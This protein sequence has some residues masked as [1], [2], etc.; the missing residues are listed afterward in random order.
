MVKIGHYIHTNHK[1]RS[2]GLFLE[3]TKY[4]ETSSRLKFVKKI[5]SLFA[6]KF[7][8]IS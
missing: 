3:L 7:Y 1:F 8:F 5:L 6:K 2:C 4:S